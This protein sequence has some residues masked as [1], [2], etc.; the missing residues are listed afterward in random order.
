MRHAAAMLGTMLVLLAGACDAPSAGNDGAAAAAAGAADGAQ[1]P[2]PQRDA[3]APATP[4]A[5]DVLQAIYRIGGQGRASYDAGDGSEVAFWTGQ[6]FE[7]GGRR[8]FAGFA[9]MTPE[10]FGAEGENAVTERDDAVAISQATYAL[11]TEG[12]A[13]AWSLASTDG[14]VGE[15]GRNGQPE[16][17]DDTRAAERHATR[18]GRLLLAVPTTGFANGTALRAYALFVFDPD[19][20]AL[21]R[22]RPWRYAGSLPAGEDNAAACDRGAA[23]PCIANTGTLAFLPSGGGGLPAVRVTFSGSAIAS[24]GKTRPLGE[25]D[26]RTYDYDQETA[27]YGP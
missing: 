7:L 5:D 23:M 26:A 24:P 21:P 25:A 12:G 19:G 15:F 11:S 4:S 3:P 1:R 27:R 10:R 13:P 6:A 14:Y 9:Y 2:E 16:A 22:D 18:D 20:V 17:V 8:Y